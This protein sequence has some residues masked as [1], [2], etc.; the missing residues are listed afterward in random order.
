VRA[1]GISSGLLLVGVLV[2]RGADAEPPPAPAPEP[3]LVEY[4]APAGCPTGEALAEQIAARTPVFRERAAELALRVEVMSEPG[5][6]LGRASLVLSGHAA[7][8]ELRAARCDEVVEALALVVAI[9][10]DP[11]ADTRPLPAGGVAAPGPA[12]AEPP[13]GVAPRAALPP[14][15]ER[16]HAV[17][18]SPPPPRGPVPPAEPAYRFVAG[19]QAAFVG[20]VAPE[21]AL[22]PRVFGGVELH[23]S[24]P[25]PS[26][27]R[28]SG[29]R[30]FSRRLRDVQGSMKLT[31]DLARADAC[32]VRLREGRLTL[33]P[34]AGL[35]VGLLRIDASHPRGAE[36]SGRI[37]A[38]VGGLIRA[39]V[40]ATD[41]LGAEVE[42]GAD[43]PLVQYRFAFQGRAALYRTV[44]V[45]M[46]LGLG[47]GVR[48][49]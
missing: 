37:W 6:V 19:A 31:A 42:I 26:S 21:L 27:V 33:E 36:D 12:T 24:W 17:R 11:N 39:S 18:R 34:C 9:L 43:V 4:A 16:P 32:F 13:P 48:F 20:A 41:W 46:H 1:R 44:P 40:A 5:G 8:R 2:A 3:P 35:D 14:Q 22:G 15:A 30:L 7:E 28:L 29:A 23:R 47:L 10:V 49:P 38:D 45:G 25:W